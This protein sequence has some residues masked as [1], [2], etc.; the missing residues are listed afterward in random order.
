MKRAIVIGSS[1]GIGRALAKELG[2]NGY[3][4][5]LAGRRTEVMERLRREIATRT[6][7]KAIDA[8]RPEEARRALRELVDEMGGVDLI[9]VNSGVG[10]HDPDW[11]G[12]LEILAVNVVGFAALANL[13]LD[14]FLERGSGHL[15]GISSI[16]GL[17]GL[18]PAY[19]GSKAFA[20]TYLEG[21][22]LRA[23]RS[24]AAVQVTDVK[25]GFV[26]T[27]MTENREDV[28]WVASA[29]KAAA[30]ICAAIRKRRRHVYVTRRWRLV[31]WLMKTVPYALLSRLVRM[32]V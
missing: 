25:P 14:Y 32:R 23:D 19:S 10:G 5:G 17:R 21:L 12:E 2:A 18:R 20:S 31:A 11:Q 6:Y 9:V 3:E 13:A 30:Q 29:E 4:V 15:V 8:R 27:A 26:A 16:A 22:R 24:G 1:S 7:V 28:F